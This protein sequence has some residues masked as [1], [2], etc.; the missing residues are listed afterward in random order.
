MNKIYS[1]IQNFIVYLLPFFLVLG[2]LD[3]RY[4][5]Y[6][7]PNFDVFSYLSV[8]NF[9][10]YFSLFSLFLVLFFL[11]SFFKNFRFNK[12][13]TLL[14]LTIL[15]GGLVSI[16]SNNLLDPILRNPWIYLLQV[17]VL[18]ALLGLV[19]VNR[20]KD[21][22][23][24]DNFEVSLICCFSFLALLTIVQFYF[25]VFPGESMDFMGRAVWPYIDPFADMKPESAN[26][27]AFIYAPMVLLGIMK[28]IDGKKWI[29]LP[30]L[31]LLF[32]L[33]L[34]ESYG[35]IITL[36]VLS[37]AYLFVKVSAKARL[38][39]FAFGILSVLV[40][41]VTQYSSPK[42]QALIGNYH[43]PNS[44]ERRVQICEFNYKSLQKNLFTGLGLANYQSNFR[45]NQS[46]YLS[47]TIPEVELPPHPHNLAFNF[48][49][50]LGLLGLISIIFIYLY[51]FYNLFKQNWSFLLIMYPL[52][53]GLIDTPYILE[54]TT[55]MF[56]ILL[57]LSIA[58]SKK[59]FLQNS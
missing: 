4:H 37:F 7:W 41:F 26:W 56:W 5:S 10:D 25:N 3:Y 1:K 34:S 36:F 28:A 55:M 11:F 52:I 13:L 46:N 12:I 31:I 58:G 19:L 6:Y 21:K 32:A 49:S 43:M 33:F 30:S 24:K 50:D 20:L 51:A 54:E 29:I 38:G 59:Q 22:V 47:E 44:I 27:L 48:W 18:P 15:V 45:E 42:F 16:F 9:F 23:V 35:G 14:L 8:G 17:Y 57:A 53:H 39:L 2:I 40:I